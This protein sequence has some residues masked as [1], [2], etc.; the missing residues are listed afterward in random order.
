MSID[1][2]N[3]GLSE[4]V[5]QPIL[6]VFS[7]FPSLEK[8]VLYGSRAKGNYRNGSDID[9][10]FFGAD[11]TAEQLYQ[12][13]EELEQLLLPYS[14]DLSLHRDIENPN[15]LDHIKRVGRVFYERL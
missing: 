10:T 8:V 15:F 3:T 14:F 7:R 13:D 2:H 4:S 11:F 5:I 6:Q 12:I 9:L 1:Y